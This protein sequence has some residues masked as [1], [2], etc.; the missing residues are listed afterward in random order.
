LRITDTGYWKLD[1]LN[2]VPLP[3]GLWLLVSGVAGF[4]GLT[5]RKA[6]C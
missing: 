2:P 3:A 6:A 1:S 4:F 5:R